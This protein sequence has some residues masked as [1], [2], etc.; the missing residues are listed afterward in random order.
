M[1]ETTSNNQVNF[2]NIA[3]SVR[4]ERKTLEG[5][6]SFDGAIG[7]M[8]AETDLAAS[9]LP[10]L[11][12]LDWEG[13]LIHVAESLP[14]FA[15][16]LDLTDVNNI[17]AN[18]G[19]QSRTLRC[20]P[21]ELDSRLLPCLFLPYNGLAM[22]LVRS[23]GDHFIVYD[24]E[25]RGYR[26]IEPPTNEGEVHLFSPLSEELQSRMEETPQ[27]YISVTMQRFKPLFVRIFLASLLSNILVL[28]TPLL[29]KSVY[30][31]YL[32]TGSTVLLLS[33]LAGCLI[34]V[35]GDFAMRNIRSRMIAYM[36]ARID[37]LL[38]LGIF[39]RLLMLPPAYTEQANSNAQIARLRDFEMVREFFTG[40]LATTMAEAPFVVIFILTMA[41]LGG[42]LALVPVGAILLFLIVAYL[43][44]PVVKEKLGEATRAASARQEFL[45]EALTEPRTIKESGAT[46]I[47]NERFRD[48]SADV[49]IKSHGANRVNTIISAGAQALVVV[50]GVMTLGYGVT[51]VLSGDMTVGGLMA[52]MIIVWWILRPLQTF[53]SMTVQVDR[54]KGAAAQINRLMQLRPERMKAPSIQAVPDF[55]GKI[56]IQNVSLRYSA[57]ADPA[58]LGLNLDVQ[59]G[60]IVG[61]VGPNGSGKS[62]ILKLLLGMY[63]PQ[64]GSVMIDGIDIRQFDQIELRRMIAYVPQKPDLFFGTVAQNLRLANPG[65]TDEELM[66]ACKEADILDDVME[67][68][69]KFN[70]RLGDGRND[71]YSSS[72]RQ[73]LSL[74][75]A[76]VKR[77]PIILMD[78]PA[79]S[80]DFMSDRQLM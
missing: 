21:A 33:L 63:R 50:T 68:P 27:N 36:G 37:Y 17:M 23:V 70:T 31:F 49:A 44:N 76:Y 24:T 20:A 35:F 54:V 57:E 12:A 10:L 7:G 34:A 6:Y 62:T 56:D 8:K 38:G 78:E 22:V 19:Y 46:E 72:F 39:R 14:H 11:S 52:S 48:L 77:A 74:A 41:F 40:P 30:D 43:I 67:L 15:D 5:N 1:T 71:Q 16:T 42:P 45:I 2:E 53:F 18:L 66:W 3:W 58:V 79:S 59:P 64:T 80:L 75:R 55:K 61:L 69:D 47:W 13:D 25:V 28:S 26:T 9:I 73:R 65:A 29:I 4:S 51:R 60:E 32:P